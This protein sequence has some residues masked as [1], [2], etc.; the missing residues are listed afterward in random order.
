MIIFLKDQ[1]AIIDS[2]FIVQTSIKDEGKN[3]SIMA[4]YTDEARDSGTRCLA[5]YVDKTKASYVLE[6]LFLAMRDQENG[7][8]FPSDDKINELIELSR[9]GQS[10][11]HVKTKTNRHGG[12]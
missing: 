3:A 9:S 8:E 7:F 10:Q 2:R 4:K 5:T 6:M 1:K 11:I 12:S